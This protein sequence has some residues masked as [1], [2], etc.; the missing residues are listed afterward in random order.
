[1]YAPHVPDT[2]THAAEQLTSVSHQVTDTVRHEVDHALEVVRHE[3]DH[4]VDVLLSP[5]AVDLDRM[6][7]DPSDETYLD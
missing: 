4:A 3:V 5:V 6:T 1:M 2:V 7:I